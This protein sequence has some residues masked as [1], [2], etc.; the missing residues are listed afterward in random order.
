MYLVIDSTRENQA[1]FG[2]KNAASFGFESGYHAVAFFRMA[3][4]DGNDAVILQNQV[5]T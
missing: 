1:S 5:G 2:R 4:N 3:G